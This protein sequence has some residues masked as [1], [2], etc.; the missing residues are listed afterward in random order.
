MVSLAVV[1]QGGCAATYSMVGYDLAAQGTGSI[2]PAVGGGSDGRSGSVAAGFSAGPLALEAV[3]RG[4]DLE[5]DAD[6]WLSAAAGME[7]KLRVL[8]LG[9]VQAYVH[10][11]A[12]RALVLDRDAMEVTWGVGYTYGGTLALGKRGVHVYVDMHVEQLSY[13]GSIIDGPATIRSTSAGLM[14]GR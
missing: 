7:L 5:T 8:N 10:G 3:M 12:L 1:V 6:R 2:T 4:H 9:P 14:V 13:V 11:G